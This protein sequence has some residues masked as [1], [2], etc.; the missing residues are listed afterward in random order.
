MRIAVLLI[1]CVLFASSIQAQNTASCT[2]HFR[3]FEIIEPVINPAIRLESYSPTIAWYQDCILVGYE[4]GLWI[5]DSYNPEDAIQL[6]QI[7]DRAITEITIAEATST[8]AFSVSQDPNVYLIHAD[9][10]V[11][12]LQASGDTITDISFSDDGSLVA[13]ASS[14]VFEY[15]GTGFNSN[16]RV[17]IWNNKQEIISTIQRDMTTILQTFITDD[18]SQVVFRGGNDG[19]SHHRIEAY[20]IA[21]TSMIWEYSGIVDIHGDWLDDE[22]ILVSAIDVGRNSI[23]ISGLYNYHDYDEYNGVAINIWTLE[24]FERIQRIDVYHRPASSIEPYL[25]SFTFNRDGTQILTAQ[26]G[27]ILRLWD[28]ADASILDEFVL[29]IESISQVIFSSDDTKF[30]ITT[31]NE[32]AIF[33]VISGQIISLFAP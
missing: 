18:N 7:E 4:N 19:Y 31:D 13:V 17:Q 30:A 11:S 26:R 21:T 23:A 32:I 16:A 25:D 22:P 33:D 24:P 9:L 6:A 10:S 20:E 14:E 27:G 8:I 15:E 3:G 2:E 5:Y 29:D 28:T 12:T 1:F